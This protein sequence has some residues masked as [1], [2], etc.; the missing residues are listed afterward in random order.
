MLYFKDLTEIQ[1]MI[2]VILGV[3]VFATT[4]FWI[5]K[6]IKPGPQVDELMTRT[7]SWWVMASIFTTA[8]LVHPLISF[9]AFAFL[10][11]AALREL[12]SISKNARIEDRSVIF[13][14]YLAI[15]VQYLFAYMGCF[16]TFVVFIPVFM[17]TW[18]PFLLVLKGHTQDIARSM[19]VIPTHLML[20]VFSISHLAYLLSLPELPHFNAGG[21]GLLLFVVFLT[22]MND[23]FQF[24]WGKLLGRHKIIEKISPNKTWEGFIGGLVLTC[25]FSVLLSHYFHIPMKVNLIVALCSVVFGTLGDLVESMLKREFQIKDS[26][27]IL[28]GHGGI[29]DRFDALL[30]SLPFTTFCYYLLL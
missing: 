22:E 27:T 28:P 4:L 8:A 12:S 18:I 30:I 29:L 9:A 11:F 15:P 7:K 3:L 26:G 23:V 5:W 24:T 14:A 25:G 17:F 1:Q 21:R 10:S 6:K 13:W 19:S 2:L 16:A 20:T